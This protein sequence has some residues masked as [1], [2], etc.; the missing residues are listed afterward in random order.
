M[1]T[2]IWMASI[3]GVAL[4]LGTACDKGGGGE[5]SGEQAGGSESAE[6]QFDDAGDRMAYERCVEEIP[7]IQAG[8]ESGDVSSIG[9]A[10]VMSYAQ[11]ISDHSDERVTSVAHQVIELC[12][13]EVPLAEAQ[14]ELT[15]AEQARAA[16]PAAIIAGQ[17]SMANSKLGRVDESFAQDQRVADMRSHIQALCGN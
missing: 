4:L 5:G 13:L 15:E 7:N 14:A 3:F 1:R 17:C 6:P 8:L 11:R 10:G 9:C 2:A 16:D 12:G